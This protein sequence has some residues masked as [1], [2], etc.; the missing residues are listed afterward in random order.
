MEVEDL[1][2]SL[3]GLRERRME[4]RLGYRRTGTGTECRIR[5]RMRMQWCNFVGLMD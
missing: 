2:E 4:T 3:N 1:V 5:M